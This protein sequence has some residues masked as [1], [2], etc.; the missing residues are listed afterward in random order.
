MT[1]NDVSQLPPEL[2]RSGRID[3]Q[4][5]F[6]LPNE[7]EREEI[8]KI[9]TA[10]NK[11]EINAAAM[12]Y[13]V[14]AT[15]NFTGAEIKSAVKDAM[16]NSFYRQKENSSTDF[17]REIIIDDIKSAVTNTV[18]V[19]RSSKEKIEAFRAYS[20]DRYLNASRSLEEIKA[21]KKV[22]LSKKTRTTSAAKNN[23]LTIFTNTAEE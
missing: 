7:V 22:S 12:L 20:Q 2:T 8:I 5:M 15:D 16:I 3:A 21:E 19:W 4:W 13:M 18:T 10:K 6:D 17:T 14:Q 9:Y 23:V 11:L 1:S